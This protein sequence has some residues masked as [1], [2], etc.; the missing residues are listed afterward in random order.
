MIDDTIPKLLTLPQVAKVLQVSERFAYS[1]AQRGELPTVRM[2]R[3][4]RVR[5]A[6]LQWFIERNVQNGET[7]RS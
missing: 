7:A 5:P 1:L 4:V 6:D 2:G 3:S